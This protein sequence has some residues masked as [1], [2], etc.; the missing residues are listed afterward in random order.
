MH[1]KDRFAPIEPVE[2]VIDA[3]LELDA[4][5]ASHGGTRKRQTGLSS[6]AVFQDLTPSAAQSCM[7]S[8][9][10]GDGRIS[11]VFAGISGVFAS[12]FSE[13]AHH[14]VLY[15]LHLRRRWAHLRR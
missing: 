2:K 12:I 15:G 14:S 11:A 7:V 3:S 4:Y 6:S 5:L 9:S 13:D 8:I 1:L 10:A